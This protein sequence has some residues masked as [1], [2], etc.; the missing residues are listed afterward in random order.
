MNK[1]SGTES[2]EEEVVIKMFD[3]TPKAVIA[4]AAFGNEAVDMRVPFEV[5]AKVCRTIRKP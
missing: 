3:I 4:V 1:K 5:S 2:I